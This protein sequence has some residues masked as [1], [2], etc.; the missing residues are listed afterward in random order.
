MEGYYIDSL[1]SASRTASRLLPRAQFLLGGLVALYVLLNLLLDSRYFFVRQ[2][3]ARF[4]F[5]RNF[6]RAVLLDVVLKINLVG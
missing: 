6:L 3:D 5:I 2:V 4:H 1:T